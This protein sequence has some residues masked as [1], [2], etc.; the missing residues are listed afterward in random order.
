MSSLIP[1]TAGGD[2]TGWE[3]SPALPLGLEFNGT[4]PGRSTSDTGAITGTPTELSDATVTQF[5]LTTQTLA[6]VV[7]SK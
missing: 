1:V 7:P 3:I 2:I 4:M 6:K 5:G